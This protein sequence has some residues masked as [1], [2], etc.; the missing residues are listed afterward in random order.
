MRYCQYC[1][2][3][4]DDDFTFCPKCSA[5]LL[6]R[7]EAEEIIKSRERE[8]NER[9]EKE[10]QEERTAMMC[11]KMFDI[12]ER[13]G[14]S[15]GVYYDICSTRD[16]RKAL[17]NGNRDHEFTY[18]F[19]CEVYDIVIE[20]KMHKKEELTHELYRKYCGIQD[21]IA[22]LK[23]LMESYRGRDYPNMYFCYG[24][25]EEAWLVGTKGYITV[26]CRDRSGDGYTLCYY[27][28]ERYAFDW[29]M[30]DR[31][32]HLPHYD[33]DYGPAY[34]LYKKEIDL[35]DARVNEELRNYQNFLNA[36]YDRYSELRVLRSKELL[37]TLKNHGVITYVDKFTRER[38]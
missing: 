17:L 1:D 15:K 23:K 36:R 9:R 22:R 13:Y 29:G 19:I 24:D 28:I 26:E 4:F 27:D 38:K 25:F 11:K 12:L 6:S 30:K 34:Y 7:A 32:G 35:M 16:F 37:E 31:I 10:Q 8:A 33:F 18:G 2:R 5:R 21:N 3:G 14:A 20:H